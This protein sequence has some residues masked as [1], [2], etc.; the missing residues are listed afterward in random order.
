MSTIPGRLIIVSA[1][2]GGGKTSL[3]RALI[4]KLADLGHAA[5]IS[6]SYTTRAPRKGE[7]AGTHYHF[8]N[9][10]RFLGMIESGEFLEHAH[11]FGRRY[12]TGRQWTE[13]LLATGVDVI[14]DIDWQGAQQVRKSRPD[15]SSIFILP[16][17]LNELERRLRDRGQDD[18]ATIAGRMAAARDE[19]SHYAEYDALIINDQFNQALEEICALFLAPRLALEE[20]VARFGGLISELLD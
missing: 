9:E 20:Q 18:D 13:D 1:P 8:V 10:A 19:M 14:L 2:S 17:S 3:T 6:V 16:P 7:T 15:S 4:S 12:G 11:V 5:T